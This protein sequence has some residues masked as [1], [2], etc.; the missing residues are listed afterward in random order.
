MVVENAKRALAKPHRPLRNMSRMAAAAAMVKG[1]HA[2]QPI[3]PTKKTTPLSPSEVKEEQARLVALLQSI[4]PATVVDQICKAL[5]F[6]GTPSSSTLDGFP[7]SA[8][9]NGTGTLFVGWIAEIFPDLNRDSAPVEPI[10]PGLKGL[11]NGSK[12][13]KSSMSNVFPKKVESG[14]NH[15]RGCLMQPT[16]SAHIRMARLYASN[17]G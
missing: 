2:S 9:A 17:Q 5:A 13:A 8:E 7:D 11:P 3:I 10:Q 14:G 6:F 12:S 4:D 1:Q 15:I 16:D